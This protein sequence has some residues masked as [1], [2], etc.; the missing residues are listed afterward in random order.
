MNPSKNNMIVLDQIVKLIPPKLIDKLA[1]EYDVSCHCRSFSPTSHVVAMMYGQLSHS[2]SLNDI[3]DS[4]RNHSGSL[5]QIRGATPP[6][7]NGL[8]HANLIRNA[9][10]AEAL[11]WS[12]KTHLETIFPG[13][14]TG[15]IYPGTPR[16]FKRTINAVDSTTIKL[17]ANCMDWAK[18]R[19]RK[20]AAKMHLRLN[21]GSFL[22]SFAIVQRAKEHDSILAHEMCSDIKAGEIVV[23]DKGYIDFKHYYLLHK[24]GVFWVTRP[25]D[26]MKYDVVGQH[27]V[28]SNKIISDVQIKLS[29]EDTAEDYPEEL[30]LVEAWVEVNK[31]QVVMTFITNNFEWAASSI[32]DL[33]RSRWGIE[34]F[35]K[36]IKQTLQL[37]DFMGYSENAVRWQVWTALLVYLLLRFIAWQSKWSQSFNRLFTVLR[38]VLWNFFDM[39]SV[40]ECCGTAGGKPRMYITYEQCVLPGFTKIKLERN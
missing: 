40:L 23:F 2:L 24:R 19:R 26:N 33:Y 35:F 14:G 31:E 12:V 39:F 4:M 29:K 27:T 6:S 25:K 15:R 30:R 37:A 10:M 5:S 36:E 3:C 11:F 9:D 7:R 20:A 16:R 21:M 18:H 32:C 13:F 1:N 38:G 17:V 28:N 34:V 8:S 22:P